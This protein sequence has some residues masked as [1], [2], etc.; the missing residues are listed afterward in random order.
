MRMPLRELLLYGGAAAASMVLAVPMLG[1][2]AAT[3]H[4]TD[5]PGWCHAPEFVIP[6][7]IL[8]GQHVVTWCA[9]PHRALA[10]GAIYFAATGVVTL[11][12]GPYRLSLLFGWVRRDPDS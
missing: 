10:A 7:D 1:A 5:Y 3:F 11:L 8:R 4:L 12:R 2:A 6:D 9:E